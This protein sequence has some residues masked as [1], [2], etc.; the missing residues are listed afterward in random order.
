ME[1]IDK[2]F[3]TKSE[4]V[5]AE[6]KEI[7]SDSSIMF[8]STIMNLLQSLVEIRRRHFD[9]ESIDLP[10]VTLITKNGRLKGSLIILIEES[11]IV[12][13]IEMS[14]DYAF[15]KVNDIT[16]VVIH[17]YFQVQHLVEGVNVDSVPLKNRSNA[18][19]LGDIKK[20]ISSES[21]RLSDKFG[22]SIEI[23]IDHSEDQSNVHFAKIFIVDLVSCLISV[24]GRLD[25]SGLLSSIERITLSKSD[26][27][28]ISKKE[29][30]LIITD[31]FSKTYSTSQQR[32][33][34]KNLIVDSIRH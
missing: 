14:Q 19:K 2:Q 27:F 8:P 33:F 26:A 21:R 34:L 23:I 16:G 15:I 18:R 32:M 20:I 11:H 10:T 25:V 29:K 22:N 1:I 4:G 7:S 3:L 13:H 17:N 24:S 6:T 31:S 30:N 5:S 12:F 9:G 28:T